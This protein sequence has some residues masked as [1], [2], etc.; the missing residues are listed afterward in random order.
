MPRADQARHWPKER[1]PHRFISAS[2]MADAFWSSTEAGRAT[3]AELQAPFDPA[4]VDCAALSTQRCASQWVAWA[5][6]VAYLGPACSLR[7][8]C[9]L[10]GTPRVPQQLLT[11]RTALPPPPGH[12]FGAGPLDRLR[13]CMRRGLWLQ[14]GMNGLNLSRM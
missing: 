10:G 1:A 11:C 4:G 12:R 6:H 8:A 9:L 2:E 14:R 5:L 7:S 13:A 3:L